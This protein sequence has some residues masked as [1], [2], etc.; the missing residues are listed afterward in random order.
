MAYKYIKQI[1]PEPLRKINHNKLY[2]CTAIWKYVSRKKICIFANW[3]ITC[4][5]RVNIIIKGIWIHAADRTKIIRT[6]S[7]S[8]LQFEKCRLFWSSTVP[9]MDIEY[10]MSKKSCIIFCKNLW[11]KCLLRHILI[12]RR[13]EP[14]PLHQINQNKIYTCNAISLYKKICNLKGGFMHR[15]SQGRFQKS[16]DWGGEGGQIRYWYG[17]KSNSPHRLDQC[18]KFGK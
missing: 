12:M 10:C 11:C 1:K 17:G 13:L 8:V 16:G 4:H 9:C 15:P 18:S 6:D 5:E 3:D 14:K 7:T 2:A